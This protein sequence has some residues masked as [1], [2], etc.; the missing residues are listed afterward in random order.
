VSVTRVCPR[1]G[2]RHTYAT[3]ALADAH[4]P[5]HSCARQQ[6]LNEAA[7]R[8]RQRA[9]GGPK[10]DCTHPGHPHQH[11]QRVAYVKDRCRCLDCTA[12]NTAASHTVAREQT[13]GR[14]SPYVE[15]APVRAHIALLRSAGIGYDQIAR[16]SGTSA[17]HVRE[18]AATVAR[19]GNRPA[20]QQ[21]RQDRA[22]RILAVAPI[23]A[24]RAPR[25]QIDATGTRRRLQA[26]VAIGWAPEALAAQLGRSAANLRRTMTGLTVHARTAQLVSDLYDRLWDT[27][28][29]QATAPQRDAAEA[30]RTYAAEHGWLPPLAWDDIDTDP[31]PDPSTP[32][33]T[34]TH[35]DLDEIAIERAVAG[36]GIRLDDLTAAEQAEVVRRLTERGKSIRDIADQ[37][38][39]TKRTVSRRRE[40]AASAA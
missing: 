29:P 24:N 33:S 15:V 7:Q 23:P 19:S 12:A 9:G 21:V 2:Y 30:S 27:P 38:A 37:L 14:W 32:V 8:R 36:D 26:L 34:P 16:L 18:I 13:F 10:R 22:H 35:D 3:A 40:S 25:S 28:A 5:R 4:H 31:E 1:C 11:G 6:R 20:I 17:T 39:T